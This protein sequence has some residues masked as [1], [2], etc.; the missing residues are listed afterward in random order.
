MI[1]IAAYLVGQFLYRTPE[2]ALEIPI[3]SADENSDEIVHNGFQQGRSPANAAQMETAQKITSAVT[4]NNH[5][6]DLLD[7][8]G[9][10][11]VVSSPEEQ[12]APSDDSEELEPGMAI[13][14]GK[15][16][17]V[18]WDA[19]NLHQ[20]HKK[21]WYK[22]EDVQIIYSEPPSFMTAED[23]GVY[24]WYER[25]GS[26]D[27]PE[28][29]PD[30]LARNRELEEVL[31]RTT[32]ENDYDSLLAA[33][34]ELTELNKRFQKAGFVLTLSK[35]NGARHPHFDRYFDEMNTSLLESL[36]QEKTQ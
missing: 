4:N 2:E 19:F 27:A 17:V 32:A 20:M 9:S 12:Q 8:T 33:T 28:P 21:G 7:S 13:V 18:D 26:P 23:S 31:K 22:P 1:P 35:F 36:R 10:V 25:Q 11:E 29:P 5:Q 30:V 14:D 15:P 3:Q 16:Q 6:S 24:L 34:K